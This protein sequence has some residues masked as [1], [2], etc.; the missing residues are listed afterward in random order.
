MFNT[1]VNHLFSFNLPS[2]PTQGSMFQFAPNRQQDHG[3]HQFPSSP[4]T[5]AAPQSRYQS[6]SQI[7]ARPQLEP[8]TRP[9]RPLP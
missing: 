4:L 7:S 3:V 8:P 5:F 6:G 1:V 9:K 2:S